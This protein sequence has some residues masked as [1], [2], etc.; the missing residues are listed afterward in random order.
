M[1]GASTDLAPDISRPLYNCIN[2]GVKIA[3]FLLY[4]VQLLLVQILPLVSTVSAVSIL[5]NWPLS[6]PFILHYL[7]FDL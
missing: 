4:W 7:S 2:D 5:Y 1:L 3:A 6:K